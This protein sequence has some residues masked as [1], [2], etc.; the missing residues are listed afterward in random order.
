MYGIK[1][2][3]NGNLL[4]WVNY[5]RYEL[6]FDEGAPWMVPELEMCL[7]VKN[8]CSMWATDNTGSSYYNPV[9]NY[10]PHE[11]EVVKINFYFEPVYDDFEED[12]GEMI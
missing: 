4:C 1:L 12:E 3:E 7:R 6:I 9:N 8:N 11:I 5:W 10:F 2:V